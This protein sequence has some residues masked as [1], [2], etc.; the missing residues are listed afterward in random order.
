MKFITKAAL[1]LG[2][3]AAPVAAAQAQ[4]A[5]F[6]APAPQTFSAAELQSYGLSE[7]EI[8]TVQDYEKAGYRIELLTPEEAEA[9]NAGLSNNNI[10]ALIG[11]VAIVVVVA[12]AV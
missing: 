7:N 8:A 12:A 9:Y 5:E 3:A 10:L 4:T 6:R 2:L 1:A 11:L